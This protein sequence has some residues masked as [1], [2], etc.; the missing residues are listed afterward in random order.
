MVTRLWTIEQ[1]QRIAAAALQA[2]F[3]G[4][5]PSGRVRAI[6]DTRAIR[7]YTTLGIISRASSMEGRTAYYDRLHVQQLVAIKRLQSEG[8]SLAEIQRRLASA[9]SA[10]IA[11]IAAIPESF[12]NAIETASGSDDAAGHPLH[13]GSDASDQAAAKASLDN[14]TVTS[15]TGDLPLW[16]SNPTFDDDD[17]LSPDTLRGQLSSYVQIPIAA[18]IRLQIEMPAIGSQAMI[19]HKINAIDVGRLASTAAPLLQELARQGLLSTKT[20]VAA[21]ANSDSNRSTSSPNPRPEKS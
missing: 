1:L 20:D 2:T 14:D 11:Q 17:D 3:Y 7:Y 9:T 18:G 21:T 8:L 16:A 4:G 12:W 19:P 5:P 15:R 13:R 6:P 10:S